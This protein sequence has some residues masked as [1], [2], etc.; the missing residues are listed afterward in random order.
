M[1]LAIVNADLYADRTGQNWHRTIFPQDFDAIDI[2]LL[3]YCH[4][5]YCRETIY[6]VEFTTNPE[7][8]VTVITKLARRANVA[9]LVIQHDRNIVIGGRQLHPDL[10]PMRDG[11]AVLERIH[12]LRQ[13]HDEQHQG[14]R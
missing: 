8:P 9:A 6:L 3:G 4:R 12:T 14:G 5:G 7:K 10:I 1:P 11:D 2:D 13:E